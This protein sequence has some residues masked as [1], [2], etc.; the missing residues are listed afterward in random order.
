[1]KRAEASAPFAAGIA[2]NGHSFTYTALKP[3]YGTG[4][5]ALGQFYEKMGRTSPL[6]PSRSSAKCCD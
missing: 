5:L 1:L 2:T 4:W 3:D 6:W